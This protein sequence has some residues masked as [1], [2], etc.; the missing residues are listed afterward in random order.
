[1]GKVRVHIGAGWGGIYYFCGILQSG[2]TGSAT[3]WGREMGLVS[4]HG[5]AYSGGP[6]IVLRQ[7]TGKWA[8][9]QQDSTCKQEW[10]LS[11]LKAVGTQDIWT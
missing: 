3:V 1:M 7:V 11:V 4:S 10:E 9:R 6:L 8:K 2:G 5:E